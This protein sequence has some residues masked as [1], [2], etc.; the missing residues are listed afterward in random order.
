M[1]KRRPEE[2]APRSRFPDG[3]RILQGR[4]EYITYTD[5]SSV[6]VWPSDR[7][8]HFDT[9][10]HTAIEIVLPHRGATV[11]ELPGQTCT[12]EA[13]QILIIPSGMPHSLTEDADTLRYLMLFEPSPL[14]NL[15]DIPGI[16]A[17][18]QGPIW[19]KDQGELHTQVSQ[20]LLKLVDCYFQKEPMW[21]TMC[22]AYLLQAY[23]LLGRDYM[24]HSMSPQQD[25]HRTIDPEIM[26]SVITY[27]SEH[28]M[29]D[30]SLE[31]AASFAGF[32]KYYF[33]RTFKEFAGISFSDYLMVKRLNAASNLLIRTGKPIRVVAMEAGF[34][35]IASFNRIF[36]EHKNCTPT[37]FRAIYGNV[38]T[39]GFEDL[40]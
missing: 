11:Y 2:K 4:Q 17:L 5:H 39:P 12:V 31:S 33:S 18:L 20:L 25:A 34:G 38:V 30:I 8:G 3:F 35:S 10:M 24:R 22:Y 28:Y 9:H 26:N 19:L 23:A 1:E 15:Q 36:R 7:P 14:Y 40:P 27:I 21:N 37:Q 29:E 32:S 16:N 13:G 6:R